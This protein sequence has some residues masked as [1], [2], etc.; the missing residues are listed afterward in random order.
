MEKGKETTHC[1]EG[2]AETG[3]AKRRR[4]RAIEYVMAGEPD[5]TE[6]LE[7]HMPPPSAAAPPIDDEFTCARENGQR[8]ADIPATRLL[9]A[10][11]DA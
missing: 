5:T 8:N 2:T 7:L 6:R 9:S 1:D 3:K 4:E 11:K 10:N